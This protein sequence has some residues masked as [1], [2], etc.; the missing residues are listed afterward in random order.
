MSIAPYLADQEHLLI[1]PDSQLNRIPFEA[2]Q[3]EAGGDYLVQQ[4][5]ISYLTSGRDLLKLETTPPSTAPALILANP[6]YDTADAAVQVASD[7]DHR[8][9][10]LSQLQVGPLPGTAAEAEAIAPL[11]PNATV[12][13]ADQATENAL[14]AAQAPRILHI[15]THGFFLADVERSEETQN[16]LSARS[17]ETP[18]PP[19]EVGIENPLL[20]SGLALA[21]FN[22]RQSGSEDGVLTALEAANLNLFGTQLVVLSACETGLGDI[23]NGEGVYGLRRTLTIAGAESQLMSLWLVSDEGTQVLMA[24]YYEKLM[25]GMGRSEA[26]RVTQLEMIAEGGQYSHPYYWA[27]FILAGDWQPLE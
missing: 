27:S 5:Q 23:A 3:T 21:G 8:S 2:L 25:S 22:A 15:A 20:R 1:S 14:K 16:W 4:Y 17:I 26:L 7:N 13:T 12:L 24:R 18:L 11:L 10:E 9:A 6:N 19:A